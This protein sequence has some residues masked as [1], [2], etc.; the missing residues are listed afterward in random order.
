MHSYVYHCTF[1]IIKQY[2]V[3]KTIPVPTLDLSS[4]VSCYGHFTPAAT[5]ALIAC[6]VNFRNTVNECF[7]DAGGLISVNGHYATFPLLAITQA[8]F[9]TFPVVAKC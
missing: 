2:F 3:G 9:T 7:E 6:Y 8:Y 1:R 5:P 4:L